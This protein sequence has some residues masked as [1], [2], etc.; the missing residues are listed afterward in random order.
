MENQRIWHHNLAEF[1]TNFSG[2]FYLFIFRQRGRKGEREGEKHL[3][4]V[5]S[6]LPLIGDLAHNQVMWPRL[7]IEPVTLWFAGWCSIHWA[8]SARALKANSW[9]RLT[10]WGCPWFYHLWSTGPVMDNS[11]SLWLQLTEVHKQWPTCSPCYEVTWSLISVDT[12]TEHHKTS[13]KSLTNHF[14]TT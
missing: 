10:I 5:V 13:G 3:C 2:R 14:T 11:L 6:H 7:G 9:S 4:V 12:R 8:T 1:K